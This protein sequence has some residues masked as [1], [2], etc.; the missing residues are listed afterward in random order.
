M[1]D[2]LLE[3]D[4]ETPGEPWAS[5]HF[6]FEAPEKWK[7][8]RLAT[9]PEGQVVGF[10]F[11]SRKADSLHTHRMA[12][13]KSFR[14]QGV[15]SALLRSLVADA[16]QQG[17]SRLTMKVA[18]HNTRAL[19]LY[20]R[21]GFH[22]VEREPANVILSTQTSDFTEPSATGATARLTRKEP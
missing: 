14:D 11:A 1:L 16:R 2:V 13:A 17:F 20:E 21:L 7:W 15:G 6:L 10:L 22:V 8:S 19:R 3:M 18:P 4:R 12:V 5:S 9:T